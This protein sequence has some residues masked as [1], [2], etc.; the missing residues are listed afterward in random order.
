[1][2]RAERIE[3]NEKLFREVN[4][5]VEDI[6]ESFGSGGEPEWVCECGDETCAERLQLG[7][8]EYREIRAH[9]DWFIVKPEH[10]VH[11]VERV[12]SERDGYTVVEKS[13]V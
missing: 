1:M 8:E 7:L 4:E 11:E 12:V 2:T 9:E 5:R 3:K 13:G 10:V 6:Q